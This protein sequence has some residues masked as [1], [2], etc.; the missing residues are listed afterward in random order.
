MKRQEIW[1]PQRGT[2]EILQL[3]EGSLNPP[4]ADEVQIKVHGAGINFAD[5]LARMG[6]YPDAPKLPAIVGYE[7]SGEIIAVG[8]GL[9]VN[10]VGQNVCAITRFGGYCSVVNT[11]YTQCALLPPELN[12]V[13]AAAL[14]VTGVTSWMILEVQAR[15]RN[16]DTILVHAAG[17]G[18]GLMCLELAKRYD[19]EVHGL[20]STGKHATLLEKGYDR[21]FDSRVPL[22]EALDMSERYDTIIDAVGGES[23]S[24][25]FDLL[26]PGGRLV[27]FGMSSNASSQSLSLGTL[28]KNMWQVPWRRFNPIWLM[29]NNKGAFGVNMGRIDSL[30]QEVQSWLGQLVELR[31]QGIISAPVHAR[32]PFSNAHE[33]HALIH[34]RENL[35]KVILVPDEV[36]E[37]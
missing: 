12:V 18:V 20:A 26:K 30:A 27:C 13:D 31:A 7:V 29:N 37:A 6:L 35:G 36:Y 19:V 23:W 4:K 32:I 5:L 16:G 8:E 33:A 1:I 14:P 17:G 34:R 10:L 3:K 21:L 15:I 11:P 24:L 22:K 9:N 25:G 28:V 2:P